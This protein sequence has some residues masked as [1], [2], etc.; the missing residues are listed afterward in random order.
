MDKRLI[1]FLHNP[2]K[3][4]ELTN[5][6]I[7][8]EFNEMMTQK[9]PLSKREQEIE[10][11]AIK[12]KEDY[13]IAR[14]KFYDDPLHWDNNKRRRH[15]LH[16]LRDSVNKYRSKKF[17]SFMPSVRFFSLLEDITDEILSNNIKNGKYDKIFNEFVS[18]KNLNVGDCN[19]FHVE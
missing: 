9:K 15:G 4:T 14:K 19:V 5:E 10:R 3:P 13:E 16:T 18:A 2:T 12:E 11:M 8:Q 7:R 1:D 6:K 17:R